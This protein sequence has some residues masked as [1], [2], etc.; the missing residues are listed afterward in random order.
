MNIG[1]ARLRLSQGERLEKGRRGLAEEAERRGG[2]YLLRREAGYPGDRTTFPRLAS[3]PHVHATFARDHECKRHRTVSLL[4]GIDLLTG[5]VHTL[6]RNRHRSRE[7]IAFLKQA[8][9]VIGFTTFMG[10]SVRNTNEARF[11]KGQETEARYDRQSDV[12]DYFAAAF[13]LMSVA[14]GP[15]IVSL[16]S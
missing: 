2:D 14:F 4:A 7:F 1:L 13:L 9:P 16:L 3:E 15:A 5:K 8:I 6:V 12:V 10:P 11:S